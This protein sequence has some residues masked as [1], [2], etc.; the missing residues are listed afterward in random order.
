MAVV[1]CKVGCPGSVAY[2]WTQESTVGKFWGSLECSGLKEGQKPALY[3]EGEDLEL[4]R[5][6]R[7]LPQELS[8]SRNTN[9]VVEL[10]G[11]TLSPNRWDFGYAESGDCSLAMWPEYEKEWRQL[12]PTKVTLLGNGD[13]ESIKKITITCQK[14]VKQTAEA[15]L[16]MVLTQTSVDLAKLVTE[17]LSS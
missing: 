2:E 17:Y 4:T 15:Y 9:I 13:N 12:D 7:S 14:C 16:Q 10:H 11:R 3:H 1:A 6:L 8:I 5:K